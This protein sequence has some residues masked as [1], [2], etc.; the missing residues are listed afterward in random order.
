M[1]VL[2]DKCECNYICYAEH[3]KQDFKNWTSG[4][5]DIDKFIQDTQL[6]SHDDAKKALEWIPYNRFYNVKYIAKGGFSKVYKANWSYGKIS[7]WDNKD[8]NWKRD[9]QNMEVVLKSLNNSKN[10]TSEFINEV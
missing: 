10:I 2:E 1:M 9:G 4:N 7:H 6:L 3:F 8:Q 5:N